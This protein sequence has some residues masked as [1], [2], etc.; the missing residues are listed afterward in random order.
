MCSLPRFF[1]SLLPNSSIEIEENW[2]LLFSNLKNPRRNT[3]SRTF[4]Y[5]GRYGNKK[6]PCQHPFHG[7]ILFENDPFQY[8]FQTNPNTCM[9]AT[10]RAAATRAPRVTGDRPGQSDVDGALLFELEIAAQYSAAQRELKKCQVM[11][12]PGDLCRRLLL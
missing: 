2:F 5:L 1:F 3:L 8:D 12:A 10:A 6:S 11:H 4:W 9:L 7:Q